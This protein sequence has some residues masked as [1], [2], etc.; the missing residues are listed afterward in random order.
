MNALKKLIGHTAIYGLSSI[1]GRMLNYALVPFHTY[2][3]GTHDYG[4]LTEIY[5]YIAFFNVLFTFGMETT[6][7]RFASRDP[8]SSSSFFSTCFW[9]IAIIIVGIGIPLFLGADQIAVSLGYPNDGHIIRWVLGIIS[10]DALVALPFAKLRLQNRGL[11]FATLKVVNI[12]INVSLNVFFL[13]LLPTV[14]QALYNPELGVGYVFLANLLANGLYILFFVKDFTSVTL[15]L[16]KSRF[17]KILKY[18]GPLVILGFAGITNEM[19][20]RLALKHILPETFYPDHSN[21]EILGIF[22]ACYKLTIFMTLAIQ[23]FKYA[24]EPFF[25]NQAENKNSKEAL[26]LVMN[27]FIIIGGMAWIGITMMVPELANFFLQQKAYHEG[28]EIVP[29]LLGSGLMMGIFYNLSAWYKLTDN[30]KYGA[31]ISIVGAIFTVVL[32]FQLIPHL[33]YS[34]SAWA[35][36]ITFS[37]M[38]IMSAVWGRKHYPIPYYWISAIFYLLLSGASTL[39]INYQETMLFRYLT[40]SIC[41]ISFLTIAFFIEKRHIASQKI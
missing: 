20:S 1:L 10:I 17:V 22:G 2:I 33:G 31:A 3:F 24:F 7:F 26:A 39:L 34:G 41:I 29:I 21:D 14:N 28:L 12:M 9:I 40:G 8:Q 36:F 35:S 5:A 32:N 11:R 6:F 27:G 13:W 4:I 25:F 15:Q 23:A 30:T 38:V 18:A 19:F 37:L 16:S